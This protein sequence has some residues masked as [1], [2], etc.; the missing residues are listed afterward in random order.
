MTASHMLHNFMCLPG[1]WLREQ[2]TFIRSLSASLLDFDNHC[3][4]WLGA[5]IFFR[6]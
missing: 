6:Q 1:A 2:N 5:E 3:F 4:K